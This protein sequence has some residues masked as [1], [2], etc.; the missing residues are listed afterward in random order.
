MWRWAIY[1]LNFPGYPSLSILGYS[2][3]SKMR[4]ALTNLT[5]SLKYLKCPKEKADITG[6]VVGA[7]PSL[8][9]V[10]VFTLTPR[11]VRF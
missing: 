6:V 9:L 7:T 4:T 5:V 2:M 11:G 10:P 3:N 8:L 1:D